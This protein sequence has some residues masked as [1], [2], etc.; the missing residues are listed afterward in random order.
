M[1][2]HMTSN[3]DLV[4][5]EAEAA[6]RADSVACQQCLFILYIYEESGDQDESYQIIMILDW[7]D[8]GN[9]THYAIVVRL[10]SMSLM[11]YVPVM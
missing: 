7:K 3:N 4:I 6:D 5:E 8:Q 2:T 11:C 9:A 10:L 1:T